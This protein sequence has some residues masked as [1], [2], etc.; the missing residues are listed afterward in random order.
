MKI[1]IAAALIAAAICAHPF[2]DG[3]YQ[4]ARLKVQQKLKAKQRNYVPASTWPVHQYDDEYWK[5]WEAQ[6]GRSSKPNEDN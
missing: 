1:I 4:D 2:I 3:K 6:Y 5:R